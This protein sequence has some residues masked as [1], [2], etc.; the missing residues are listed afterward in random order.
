M[1]LNIHVVHSVAN[2]FYLIISNFKVCHHPPI[3]A[4][5]FEDEKAGVSL[6]GHSK[7]LLIHTQWV[8]I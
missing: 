7:S 3:S 6:N 8:Y 4:F 5:Y 2:S 1:S